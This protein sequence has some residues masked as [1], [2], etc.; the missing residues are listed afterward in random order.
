MR[1]SRNKQLESLQRLQN[2]V[3]LRKVA[4]SHKVSTKNSFLNPQK[5]L[6]RLLQITMKKEDLG[7]SSLNKK[8]LLVK[9]EKARYKKMQ[10]NNFEELFY[11]V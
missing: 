8:C 10:K 5:S 11:K 7:G 3:L 1:L 2:E 9:V 4:K 6:L